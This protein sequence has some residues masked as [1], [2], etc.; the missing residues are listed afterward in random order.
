MLASGCFLCYPFGLVKNFCHH[1]LKTEMVPLVG[2]PT[3]YEPV[4]QAFTD[5]NLCR[6]QLSICK[7]N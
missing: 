4:A 2:V 3:E 6:V 5:H 1:L 7:Q